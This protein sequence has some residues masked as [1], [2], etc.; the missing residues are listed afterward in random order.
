MAVTVNAKPRRTWIDITASD[1]ASGLVLPGQLL[2]AFANNDQHLHDIMIG[3]DTD[4]S[5]Q[6]VPHDH[7]GPVE[8]PVDVQAPF[9]YLINS[10]PYGGYWVEVR[11]D[12]HYDRRVSKVTS[13][14]FLLNGVEGAMCW[15]YI[16]PKGSEQGVV[17]DPESNFFDIAKCA[18]GMRGKLTLSLYARLAEMPAQGA[19]DQGI[20]SFGVSDGGSSWLEGCRAAFHYID[21]SGTSWKR[22][23]F[24][25][26]ARDIAEGARF[27]VRQSE[28][29]TIGAYIT[30]MSVS[31]GHRLGYWQPARLDKARS[32]DEH[33]MWAGYGLATCPIAEKATS[34]TNAVKLEAR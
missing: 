15:Q 27:I 25:C 18:Y 28:Q 29:G 4:F 23:Y 13:E 26:E 32:G 6:G 5:A 10:A 3:R 16:P 20:I 9:N 34:I 11:G 7:V 24:F 8:H 22:F 1:V 30:A 31:P 17:D 14:G 2:A 19:Q 33:Y 21:L 12:W